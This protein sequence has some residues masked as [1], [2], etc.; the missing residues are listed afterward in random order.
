MPRRAANSPPPPLTQLELQQAITKLI[1]VAVLWARRSFESDPAPDRAEDQAFLR[2]LVDAVD[3]HTSSSRTLVRPSR[4]T[5]TPFREDSFV[6]V[7]VY[8]A[9]HAAATAFKK[10]TARASARQRLR[11]ELAAALSSR[12]FPASAA[13]VQRR[14]GELTLGS[15]ASEIADQVLGLAELEGYRTV[16]ALR[17][18]LARARTI[19]ARRDVS[20][21]EIIQYML[22]CLNVRREQL[23]AFAHA[24]WVVRTG[25]QLLARPANPFI[26]GTL[27]RGP[28]ARPAPYDR[29][30]APA[31]WDDTCGVLDDAHRFGDEDDQEHDG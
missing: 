17:R 28:R 12:G 7:E 5:K 3:A 20:D 23:H 24:L 30:G 26:R 22:A 27:A 2:T 21:L 14:F 18:A 31:A 15:S 16:A 10:S 1:R 19:Q 25:G 29:Y 9:I 8:E 13:A 4:S 6:L 11:H